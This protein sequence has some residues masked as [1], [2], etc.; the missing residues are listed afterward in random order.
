[1][2]KPS[3]FTLQHRS[4]RLPEKMKQMVFQLM[5]LSLKRPPKSKAICCPAWAP[6][7]LYL[8]YYI[9]GKTNIP[10]WAALEH[11]KQSL[12]HFR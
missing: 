1:M 7:W 3:A 8:L 11:I 12:R 6:Y 2:S 9:R 10:I 4:N 5:S